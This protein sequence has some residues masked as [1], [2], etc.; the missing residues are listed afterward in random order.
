MSVPTI[1]AI[2]P[3]LTSTG[4]VCGTSAEDYQVTRHGSKPCGDSC[5]DRF[6]RFERLL[7]GIVS[8]LEDNKPQ[9]ILIEN[10]SFGSK[11]SGVTQARITEFG[12]LLRWHLLEH[13][14]LVVEI[15]PS[16]LKKFVT[17]KGNAKKETMLGHVQKRWGVMFDTS[18]EA[19][20]FGL[21]RM[22]LVM[23]GVVKAETVPQAESVATVM[24][25]HSLT[26]EGVR[27]KFE[28]ASF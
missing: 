26:F 7:A 10:Y 11:Q 13:T 6:G 2:D 12:G 28:K 27:A 3:S 22:G 8:I 16:T 23:A 1:A 17:G 25:S 4:I 18:D 15:A 20:A 21:Y 14:Q 24:L 9:L 19:D 5:S